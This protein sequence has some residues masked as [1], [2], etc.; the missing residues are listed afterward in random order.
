MDT[1]RIFTWT[2]CTATALIALMLTRP[3]AAASI[4]A[5]QARVDI[6]PSLARFPTVSLAGFGER[7]GKPAQSVR[8]EIY[9]RALVLSDSHAK[10]ALVATDL[11]GISPGMKAAVVKKVAD[12]GFTENNVLLAAAHNHSA[13][14]CLHPAGDVWPLAFGK[15]L[16]EYFEFT[17]TRIAESIRA[18][19]AHMQPAQIGFAA[20]PL[21][22]FNR[23]RRETGGGLVDPT[24]TVMKVASA[25]AG[26][27]AGTLALVVNFTA[28]PTIMG[29]ESF[30]ISGEWP[31]AMS[32]SLE[33]RMPADG[34]ALF[35]NGAQGDQTHGGEF[36]SGWQRVEAYGKALADKAWALAEKIEMSSDV[37]IAVGNITWRLPEYRVSPAF[38]ESTG[39]EYKLTP[40]MANAL[41]SKLFPSTVQLQAVR[42]GDA[43]LMAVPGEAIAELGLAMKKNAAALGAGYPMVIG[44]A[45]DSIGY[46]L[47]PEQYRLGGY[48]SGTS[49]YGPQLGAILVSQMKQTVRPLFKRG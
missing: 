46:I 43:A 23:N 42:I 4:T 3:P 18:A 11:I 49:F 1:A 8:D 5:G 40:E 16:P 47:S 41:A 31:G 21:E 15:F 28:H 7:E 20:A 34:A 27:A 44:L 13:P 36:G 2:V 26:P 45:N 22:G 29:P 6:T 38:V 9:A 32:R 39:Q 10:V 24:M 19:D 25:G 17:N 48:E 30:A 12:L 37:K 14:E 35:F 33:S